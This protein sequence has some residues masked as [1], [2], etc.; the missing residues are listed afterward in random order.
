MNLLTVTNFMYFIL[1]DW[2]K[3]KQGKT[4]VIVFGVITYYYCNC[5]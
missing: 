3:L 1:G 4:I 2:K 5:K